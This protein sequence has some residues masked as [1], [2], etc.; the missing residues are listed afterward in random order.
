M[1]ESKLYIFLNEIKFRLSSDTNKI[2]NLIFL[3]SLS[4]RCYHHQ[5]ANLEVEIEAKEKQEQRQQLQ[6]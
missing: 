1:S 2:N 5:K 6:Q 3:E 4:L